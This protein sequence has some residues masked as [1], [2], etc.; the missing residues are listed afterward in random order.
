MWGCCKAGVA[1]RAEKKSQKAARPKLG[2]LTLNRL[3][4]AA[5]SIGIRLCQ[6]EWRMPK[7]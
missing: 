2:G 7:S 1:A 3:E 6:K 5:A 4:L